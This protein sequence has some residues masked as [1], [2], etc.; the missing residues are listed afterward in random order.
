MANRPRPTL[1]QILMFQS[2]FAYFGFMFGSPPWDRFRYSFD[3]AS[4]ALG[5]VAG[6]GSFLLFSLLPDSLFGSFARKLREMVERYQWAVLAPLGP[7]G[8]VMISVAAGIS[9]EF[10]FRG[11][12]QEALVQRTNLVA[13]LLLASGLFGLV[14]QMHWLIVVFTGLLGLY[15]GLLYHLSGNI[16]VPILAHIVHNMVTLF[17]AARMFGYPLPKPVV[18]ET[19]PAEAVSSGGDENIPPL[20]EKR[21]DSS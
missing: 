10:F 15:F 12:V 7:V 17:T 5:L 13:G 8:W 3:I 19:S 11:F 4:V 16:V 2:L 6:L 20:E 14:H 18:V 9:E 21:S 1:F